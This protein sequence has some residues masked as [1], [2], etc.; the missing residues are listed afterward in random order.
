MLPFKYRT[1]RLSEIEFRNVFLD[2]DVED[3]HGQAGN[4]GPN[5]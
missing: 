4:L 2:L 3:K 1:H 5:N